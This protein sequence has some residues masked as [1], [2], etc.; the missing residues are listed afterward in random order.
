[1]EYDYIFIL[2]MIKKYCRKMNFDYQH[3]SIYYLMLI[4]FIFD[5]IICILLIVFDIIF[6]RTLI[7]LKDLIQIN[8]N[9]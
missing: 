3:T 6:L 2:K 7:D 8:Q 5:V 1:M 4:H 9:A